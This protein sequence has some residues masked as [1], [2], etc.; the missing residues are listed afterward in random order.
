MLRTPAS[1]LHVQGGAGHKTICNLGNEENVSLQI[2]S[3][4]VARMLNSEVQNPCYEL[5]VRNFSLFFFSCYFWYLVAT[6]SVHVLQGES[7]GSRD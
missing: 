3:V 2:H 4:D 1:F 5:T 6:Y 7:K